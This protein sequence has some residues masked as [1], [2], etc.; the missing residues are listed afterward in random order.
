MLYDPR[1]YE[2]ILFFFR[3]LGVLN[4]FFS[5]RKFL[6]RDEWP[7]DGPF[8]FFLLEMV[9]IPSPVLI[10]EN[11]SWRGKKNGVQLCVLPGRAKVAAALGGKNL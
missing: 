9:T 2:A 7:L 3:F 6:L 11:A 4:G 1:G 5:S 10:D 8:L